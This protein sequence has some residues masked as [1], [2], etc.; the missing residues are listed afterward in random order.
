MQPAGLN[1]VRIFDQSI[2]RFKTANMNS[3]RWHKNLK[4]EFV[5]LLSNI[6]RKVFLEMSK[7]DSSINA[8]IFAF[9][10]HS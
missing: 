10:S 5:Y 7:R 8:Q 9:S 4:I 6:P 1:F 2:Y 3:A